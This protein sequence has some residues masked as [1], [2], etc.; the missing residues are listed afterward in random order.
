[1]GQFTAD[2]NRRN[3]YPNFKFRVYFGKDLVVGASKVSALTKTVA[4]AK[5]RSGGDASGPILS[6]L[7]TEYAPVTIDIPLTPSTFAD[8]KS[9]LMGKPSAIPGKGMEMS[10]G[11]YRGELIVELMNEAGQPVVQYQLFDCWV[12]EF[13]ALPELDAN[14]GAI[15]VQHLVVQYHG[16]ERL[17]LAEPVP[18]SY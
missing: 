14:N 9:E 10:L 2:V 17:P 7:A 12:S 11:Q 1:M 4:V 13:Q 18:P 15:A 8:T 5:F 16:F 3:P 6:P